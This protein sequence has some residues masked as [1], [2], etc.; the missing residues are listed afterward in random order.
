MAKT[1]QRVKWF[2]ASLWNP[3][4]RRLLP[5]QNHYLLGRSSLDDV[6]AQNERVAG[7]SADSFLGQLQPWL[8]KSVALFGPAVINT[9]TAT[10]SPL[11]V[12]F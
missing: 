4:F 2:N 8:Q 10:F 3:P 5:C 7:R 6:S 11:S 9:I 1:V 12:A